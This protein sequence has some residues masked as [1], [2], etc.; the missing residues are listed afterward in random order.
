MDPNRFDILTRAFST[1]GTRRGALTTLVGG[2]LGLLGITEGAAR[3]KKPRRQEQ[4]RR[5]KARG[6][7]QERRR[8]VSAQG[9][10]GDG[11]PKDNEC[12]RHRQCCTGYCNKQKGRCRCRKLGQECTEDRN[13][14][15]HFGQPMS[16]Q[17]RACQM[18]QAVQAPPPPPPPLSPPPPLPCTTT[19]TTG[20]C[21]G[22]TC[23][24]GTANGACGRNGAT[25]VTCTGTGVTCGGGGTPGVCGCTPQTDAEACGGQTCG[26][27]I[28]NCGQTVS[29]TGCTG[30]C[31]GLGQCQ[32]GTT[33]TA[34]G[35]AGAS[36]DLCAAGEVCCGGACLTGLSCCNAGS[37]PDPE[38]QSCT[39]Q[40][41]CIAT[42]GATCGLV[43]ECNACNA[44]G[45]CVA[46]HEGLTCNDG[47]LC[48][49]TDTCQNGACV[50]SN[51]VVCPASQCQNPG[52]CNPATG[53]CSSPTNKLNTTPCDDGDFCTEN[54]EC[55]AG[56]CRGDAI[57][58][59]CHPV[60]SQECAI[61]S[62]CCGSTGA[63][64]GGVCAPNGCCLSTNNICTAAAQCCSGV[65]APT[66]DPQI[67]RC[68]CGGTGTPCGTT[69]FACCTGTC[70]N[71]VCP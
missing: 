48:T 4:E 2:A 40:G 18:V 61:D 14:C 19:C 45:L 67:S 55:L 36:C 58:N 12:E 66:T 35:T 64:G 52:T 9:P 15:A 8:R 47:D 50:G 37:C 27:V 51:P 21:A 22:E 62:T 3:R 65:C 13:C 42:I 59:C 44:A 39:G 31:D 43:P 68:A 56:V 38:C 26:T 29:C 24:P 11:G 34:C 69:G 54:D 41:V 46:A 57:A 70:S 17:N 5:K 10:C 32:A 60:G 7:E 63:P 49:R 30:C 71:G 20:C 1:G 16:C 33:Q 28:N 25:C 6:Q 53:V 23:Q